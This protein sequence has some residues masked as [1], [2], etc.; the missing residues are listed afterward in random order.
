MDNLIS[1]SDIRRVLA[2]LPM[3]AR[4]NRLVLF[5]SHAMGTARAQ[6]D[7]DFYLDSGRQISG[8]DF[9]ALKATLEDAFRRDIDLI[10]DLDVMAGSRVLDEI[11]R[12]GVV[13][14]GKS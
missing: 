1:I 9:F 11:K 14:Y 3:D 13:V 6:S 4:V 12:H 10:P 7:L 8:F 2:S 5:G